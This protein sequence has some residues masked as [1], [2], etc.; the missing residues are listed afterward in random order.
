M[1]RHVKR[2]LILIVG[3]A[4]IVLGILGLF[5]PILQGV[6]FLLIGLAILSSEYVWAHHLLSK[7]RQRFPRIAGIADQATHRASSWLQ[8]LT[9]Q[10][11]PD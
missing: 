10:R 1:N 2:I 6:L 9:G 5:L 8:R 11:Q 3:W 7:I 4:F